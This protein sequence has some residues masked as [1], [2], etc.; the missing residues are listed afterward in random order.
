MVRSHGLSAGNVV[1]VFWSCLNASGLLQT[2]I[3][4]FIEWNKGKAS[5]ER[6]LPVFSLDE[7]EIFVN[8]IGLYPGQ[9]SEKLNQLGWNSP[10]TTS[11]STYAESVKDLANYYG[12]IRFTDVIFSYPS[13]S[14]LV[15][16]GLN[17]E[18]ESQQTTFVLGR[19]GSGK[20]TIASLLTK[21]Y[22][23]QAGEIT[24]DGHGVDLLSKN[25]IEKNVYVCEQMPKLFD[26][27]LIE[28]IKI[29]SLYPED[30]SEED[31]KV[32]LADSC[33]DFVWDLP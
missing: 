30:V 29:G 15:L 18:L 20:S 19:S 9:I 2:V 23:W 13:R 14:E 12:H 1:T 8:S 21:Q 28:N 27:P 5:A 4:H 31:I 3:G 32:A 26:I 10:S 33:A 25:W 6:L 22:K 24:I 17:M 7:E 11:F 16:T